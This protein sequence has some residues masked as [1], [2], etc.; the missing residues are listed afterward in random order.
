MVVALLTG[1]ETLDLVHGRFDA[2][3]IAMGQDIWGYAAT[4]NLTGLTERNQVFVQRNGSGSRFIC[5][6]DLKQEK[7][8]SLAY[9]N[10][11]MHAFGI[12]QVMEIFS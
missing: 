11:L 12:S 7:A 3:R 8:S 9:D 2:G 6:T 5:Q 10:R 1:L 4:S